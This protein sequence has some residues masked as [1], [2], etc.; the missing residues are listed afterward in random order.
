MEP[1]VFLTA[2]GTLPSTEVATVCVH[3]LDMF[4]QIQVLTESTR[5]ISR[6]EN[7]VENGHS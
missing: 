5:G 3:D 7:C 1:F 2:H 4:V 6:W